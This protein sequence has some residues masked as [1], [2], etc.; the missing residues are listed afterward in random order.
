MK[1]LI[2]FLLIATMCM[3]PTTAYAGWI[4]EDGKIVLTPDSYTEDGKIKVYNLF[5]RVAGGQPKLSMEL[6]KIDISIP[7]L[8]FIGADDKKVEGDLTYTNLDKIEPGFFK[9]QYVFTPNDDKYETISGFLEYEVFPEDSEESKGKM[10]V[11]EPDVPTV[12]SLTA[13]IV[14]LETRTFYDINLNDKVSGCKYKWTSSNPDIAKVNVKN[15]L[16]TAVSEGTATITCV[17]TYPDETKQTLISEV[18]VGY[19]DNAP[20]LTDTVLDLNP[21]D[22]YDI[23]V[24]N[25]IAKSKYRWASS[26]RSIVTVNSAN[27]IVK[28]K[29]TGEAY[30]TCTI[31]TPENQVI[32]LRCDINVSEPAKITE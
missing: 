30:I 15:G 5:D 13:S 23:N 17:I 4:I 19:D 18:T 28:A 8:T 16:V 29:A 31:T 27:G 12:P 20:E 10:P 11:P 3:I 21:G 26:D 22:E 14:S 9:L 24:E 32:V 6:P 1:K 7:D 2:A 25:K